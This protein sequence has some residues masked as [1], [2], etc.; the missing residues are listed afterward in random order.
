[1]VGTP[2]VSRRT[3]ETLLILIISSSATSCQPMTTTVAERC[4]FFDLIAQQGHE[5]TPTLDVFANEL[6]LTPDKSHPLNPRYL[7]VSGN[8]M[9]VAEISYRIG[10]GPFGA[11]LVLFRFDRNL[12]ADLVEHFDSLVSEVL[13]PAH[14]VTPC[15]PDQFPKTLR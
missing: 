2:A 6:G 5:L 11:E 8:G 3:L 7:M 15:K 13:A 12:D 4:V 14:K 10:M 1:M 9:T